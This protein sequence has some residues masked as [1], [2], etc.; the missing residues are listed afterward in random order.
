MRQLKILGNGSFDLREFPMCDL[1]V[2]AEN[3]WRHP[4]IEG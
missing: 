4:T 2:N 1:I 3:E